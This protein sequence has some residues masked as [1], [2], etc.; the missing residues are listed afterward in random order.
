MNNRWRSEIEA[1]RP[2]GA[3]KRGQS[4][5]V[6]RERFGGR[7]DDG[8]NEKYDAGMVHG[9]CQ[10]SSPVLRRH[11]IEASPQLLENEKPPA[12]HCRWFWRFIV[13]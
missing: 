3:R 4:D 5:I 10:H 11:A 2:A 8:K 7:E 12:G 1:K 13:K 9:T 6:Q